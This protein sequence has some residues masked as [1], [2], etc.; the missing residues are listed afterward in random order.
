M[1]PD[2]TCRFFRDDAKHSVEITIIM[3]REAHK[4]RKELVER[5]RNSIQK[6]KSRR[7]KLEEK[8]IIR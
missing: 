1:L 5:S 8:H 6:N 3:S 4:E 7:H 2:E